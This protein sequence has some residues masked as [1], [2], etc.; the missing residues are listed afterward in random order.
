MGFFDF[1]KSISG[2][3]LKPKA[4]NTFHFDYM[5]A[6]ADKLQGAEV[7]F[8]DDDIWT[9]IV[10]GTPCRYYPAK[11]REGGWSSDHLY[12][13]LYTAD[14]A[15]WVDPGDYSRLRRILFDRQTRYQAEQEQKVQQQDDLFAGFQSG[16]TLDP[17]DDDLWRC[18]LAGD[19][20]FMTFIPQQQIRGFRDAF[21]AMCAEHGGRLYKTE[22]KSAKFAVLTGP[23]SRFRQEVERLRAL[24]Y[25][26]T[27][28]EEVVQAFGMEDLWNI[29]AAQD[30]CAQYI[31]SMMSRK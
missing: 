14:Y 7:V 21:G 15:F 24:G 10:N 29:E 30:D 11:C 20:L 6:Y 9:I 19:D 16:Y 28:I 23:R 25:K 31:A 22:A 13:R 18:F 8:P 1:L 27:S 5:N 3:N 4:P 12:K 26:I 17:I 2:A